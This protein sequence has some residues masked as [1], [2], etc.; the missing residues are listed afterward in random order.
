MAATLVGDCI[1]AIGR[2]A[3][4]LIVNAD[5]FGVDPGINAGILS[6]Y[7]HGLASSVSL[8]VTMPD[9]GASCRD[10][11]ASRVPTGLHLCLTQGRAALPPAQ[12]PHLVDTAGNFRQSAQHYLL[13]RGS[14]IERGD[15]RSQIHAEF[16]AQFALARDYGIPL[17][18][19]DLH[20]HVH[21][22]AAI[23]S[24]V[25][26]L[27]PRFGVQHIRFSRE[28]AW[29]MFMMAGF[30]QAIQRKNQ[31]KWL[32]IRWLARNISSPLPT[33]DCFFGVLH[34]G[35]MSKKV[36]AGLIRRLSPAASNEICI[37]PGFPQA[38]ANRST[39]KAQQPDRF[40]T[41]PYRQIEH[42]ALVDPI[43]A[44]LVRRRGLRL[45]SYAGDVKGEY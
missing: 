20:Q 1:V 38:V 18:H 33:T 40:A 5:D 42:D 14:R 23:F 26:E 19:V 10:L 21:M 35:V 4:G 31:L 39:V 37:H 24:I 27:A 45:V 36:L 25:A 7:A 44:D 43:L 15:L 17:T 8:M 2:L 13:L 11:R 29:P 41:S 28:P 32:L 30:R 9:L 16:A 34:S 22:N 12:L 3:P 6:A